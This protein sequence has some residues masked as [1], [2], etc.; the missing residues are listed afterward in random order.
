[1]KNRNVRKEEFSNFEQQDVR[2]REDL[3]HSNSKN[4]KTG[5]LLQAE[6]TKVCIFNSNVRV[7]VYQKK[8]IH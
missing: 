7:S 8:S 1:M 2:C 5:K 6:K 3:K 4:K